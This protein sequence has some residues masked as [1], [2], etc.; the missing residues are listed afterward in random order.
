ME[1][2]RKGQY[3]SFDAII[4]SIIFIIAISVLSSYWYGVQS[5]MD[6]RSENMYNEVMRVSDILMSDGTPSNWDSNPAAVLQYGLLKNKTTYEL[7]ENKITQLTAYL[8]SASA[9]YNETR[10]KLGLSKYQI[11]VTIGNNTNPASLASMG[12]DPATDPKAANIATASR[13][14]HIKLSGVDTLATV[15]IVIWTENMDY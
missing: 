8:D 10:Q 9:H 7:D 4:A 13:V 11:Y 12:Y 1:K 5:V 3:F 14:G 6:S 15:R 2:S